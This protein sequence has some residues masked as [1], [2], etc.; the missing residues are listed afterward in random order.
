MALIIKPGRD[1]AENW[2]KAINVQ[3]PDLEIRVW[4]D[5]GNVDDIEFAELLRSVEIETIHTQETTLEQVFID[6]TGR[7]LK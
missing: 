1:P 2:I 3:I 6:V 7:G 4:P 5:C